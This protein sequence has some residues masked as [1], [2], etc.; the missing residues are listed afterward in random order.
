[1]RVIEGVAV[2]N[3]LRRAAPR[4]EHQLQPQARA[5]GLDVRVD[6]VRDDFVQHEMHIAAESRRYSLAPC[7]GFEPLEENVERRLARGH[8]YPPDVGLGHAGAPAQLSCSRTSDVMSAEASSSSV[9]VVRAKVSAPS[10][11]SDC[12]CC[13][14]ALA[15]S[16]RLR[17]LCTAS[18]RATA[19]ASSD[20]G[21]LPR[22]TSS[23]P[24]A[25]NARP[26]SSPRKRSA[27]SER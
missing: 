20:S 7:E 21:G 15:N 26:A 13:G 2:V 8:L 19:H 18:V 4:I 24:A 5:A 1:Q 17:A 16:S 11:A 3:D 25:R 27:K 6:D 12:R 22:E 9:S 23:R 10:A 14:W